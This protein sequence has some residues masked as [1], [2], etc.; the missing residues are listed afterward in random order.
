MKFSGDDLKKLRTSAG[1]NQQQLAVKLGITRETVGNLERNKKGTIET[2]EFELM[3]KWW[4][5]CQA[6]A[7]EQSKQQFVKKILNFFS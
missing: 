4:S 6:Q 1:L 2:I 3:R 5:V 7:D